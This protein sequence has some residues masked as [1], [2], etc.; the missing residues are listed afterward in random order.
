M[1]EFVQVIEEKKPYESHFF[2]DLKQTRLR[3]NDETLYSLEN[4]FNHVLGINDGNVFTPDQEEIA[5]FAAVN[6][7]LGIFGINIASFNA[8]PAGFIASYNKGNHEYKTFLCAE[9]IIVPEIQK[10]C[11]E[12]IKQGIDCVLYQNIKDILIKKRMTLLERTLL[13]ASCIQNYNNKEINENITVAY[14]SL[15]DKNTKNCDNNNI[16]VGRIIAKDLG[17]PEE[18]TKKFIEDILK[19]SGQVYE[20]VGASFEDPRL[21]PLERYK[22]LAR[23]GTNI[24]SRKNGLSEEE[25]Q[26]VF[27]GSRLF[28][29]L[30]Y[31]VILPG[32]YTYKGKNRNGDVIAQDS[33][34]LNRK[35]M[36]ETFKSILGYDHMDD[37][38]ILNITRL[39]GLCSTDYSADM[40]EAVYKRIRDYK[41]DRFQSVNNQLEETIKQ[42]A[43][44][45]VKECIPL[46]PNNKEQKIEAGKELSGQIFNKK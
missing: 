13:I 46:T 23:S 30:M 40:T 27:E 12:K 7:L 41:L 44:A 22:E 33:Q 11:D 14:I 31:G 6:Y 39:I 25:R 28:C 19:I 17:I 10:L 29:E 37:E 21:F 2:D 42:D 3:R 36:I 18:K 15:N 16:V 1:E 20:V 38:R 5:N 26:K 8:I 32:Y 45:I 24:Y 43:D 4:E 35:E 34:I 9:F